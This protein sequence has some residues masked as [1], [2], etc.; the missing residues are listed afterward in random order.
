MNLKIIQPLLTILIAVI[1]L[2]NGLFC[3][4]LNWVPRHEMIVVRILGENYAHHLILI[5]GFF[6]ILIAVWILSGIKQKLNAIIQLIIIGSM[7]I[8]EFIF[9]EDL[10]LW[11]TANLFFA[12]LLMII[13][14]FNAFILPKTKPSNT[15]KC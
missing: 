5:I 2:I 11:G 10:L 12:I 6:E 15:L 7:N 13:I 14:Y 8:I 3:K 4:V 9:A 1:W